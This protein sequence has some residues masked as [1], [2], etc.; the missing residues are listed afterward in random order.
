MDKMGRFIINFHRRYV[1]VDPIAGTFRRYKTKEDYPL[2]PVE[3]I[4]L[5]DIA[6]CKKIV[7]WY[8]NTFFLLF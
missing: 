1:E 5:R 4:P 2:N 6:S 8:G 7:S 3:S